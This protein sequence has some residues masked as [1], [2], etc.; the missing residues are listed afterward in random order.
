[1]LGVWK[2]DSLVIKKHDNRAK[3]IKQNTDNRN[4]NFSL[5]TGSDENAF[6]IQPAVGLLHALPHDAV[7]DPV[8]D[9]SL[10]TTQHALV[11]TSTEQALPVTDVQLPGVSHEECAV[12]FLNSSFTTNICDSVLSVTKPAI[13]D[14]DGHGASDEQ[15]DGHFLQC[16]AGG[17]HCTSCRGGQ[18]CGDGLCRQFCGRKQSVSH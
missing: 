2:S 13:A 1:M 16:V 8:P 14:Y 10:P 3:E 18:H 17:L 7:L 15:Y 5:L 4:S 6:S 12:G 9:V 11:H